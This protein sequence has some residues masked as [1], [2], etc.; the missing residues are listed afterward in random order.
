MFTS[1]QTSQSQLYNLTS[2]YGSSSDLLALTQALS[3][4]GIQSLS[5]IVINHRWADVEVRKCGARFV[6]T[7]WCG[8]GMDMVWAWCGYVTW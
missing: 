5:D 3:G 1:T 6:W 4:A 2:S 8:H 7:R